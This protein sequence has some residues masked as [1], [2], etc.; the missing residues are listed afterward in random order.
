VTSYKATGFLKVDFYK[1]CEILKVKPHP[2]ILACDEVRRR[3]GRR[4]SRGR[5][6]RGGRRGGADRATSLGEGQDAR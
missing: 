2:C 4:G 3:A 6:S 1:Y 5:V